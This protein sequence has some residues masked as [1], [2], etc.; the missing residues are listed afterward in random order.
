MKF[1]NEHERKIYESGFFAGKNSKL[2]KPNYTQKEIEELRIF[3]NTILDA[4]INDFANAVDHIYRYP[5]WYK[6]IPWLRKKV[7]EKEK[8]LKE[9]DK[10]RNFL[11]YVQSKALPEYLEHINTKKK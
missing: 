9:Y 2:P 4:Y 3:L 1:E 5:D 7:E 10:A 6:K 8:F 11:C